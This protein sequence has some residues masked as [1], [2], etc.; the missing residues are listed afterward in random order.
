[1]FQ[2]FL[3][4]TTSAFQLKWQV[5]LSTHRAIEDSSACNIKV[6]AKTT[7]S[8]ETNDQFRTKKG[9]KKKETTFPHRDI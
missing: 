9:R 1:M 8:E 7:L 4:I 2:Q 6:G 5:Y 3:V